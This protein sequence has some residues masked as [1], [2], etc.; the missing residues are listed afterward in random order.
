MAKLL[1]PHVQDTMMACSRRLFN[2]SQDGDV[3]FALAVMNKTIET[4]SIAVA[5]LSTQE[6]S[7]NGTH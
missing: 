7:N 1:P 4:L 2:A 3:D 6:G 5:Y